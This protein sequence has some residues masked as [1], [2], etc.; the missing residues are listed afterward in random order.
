M[1]ETAGATPSTISRHMG[2]DAIDPVVRNY[3]T[4]LGLDRGYRRSMRATFVTTALQN[5]AAPEDVQKAAGHRDPGD[6]TVR[7]A[8]YNPEK[9]ASFL[10]TC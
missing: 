5:G 1:R 8:R 7:P 10:A 6:Q 9:V 3:A 4:E 2:L